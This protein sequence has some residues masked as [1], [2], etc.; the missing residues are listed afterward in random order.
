MK[1]SGN[2]LSCVRGLQP[3]FDDLSFVVD[4][5][6][7]LLLRGRNGAGKSSLLRI[8]ATLM[9]PQGGWLHLDNDDVYEDIDAYRRKIHYIGH[10]DA[11]KS[12]LTVAE[13]IA[14]W[15]GQR[16][17][18]AKIGTALEAL[19]ISHLADIPVQMLSAGQRRRTA[20][21]RLVA[22]NLPIWF[23][24]EPTNAL[25]QS[26]ISRLRALIQDHCRA[27]GLTIIA[28]HQDLGLKNTR[29]LDLDAGMGA[30]PPEPAR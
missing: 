3:V 5:G 14:F 4:G 30:G 22:T 15:A 2:K 6:D 13:N 20:L 12:A 8:A 23:L 16:R 7:V 18:P 17:E 26:G 24:D 19:D 10:T 27:F 9:Q 21:A 28:T 25:D 1:L 29:T 11:L